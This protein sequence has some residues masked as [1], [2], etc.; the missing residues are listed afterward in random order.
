MFRFTNQ[1]PSVILSR[2]A[3]SLSPSNSAPR[4][5]AAKRTI[6]TN[7]PFSSCCSAVLG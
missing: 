5:S 4:A 1:F 6:P 2:R 3:L 7:H